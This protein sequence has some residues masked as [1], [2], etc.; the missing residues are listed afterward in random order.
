MISRV[1]PDTSD[2]HLFL[3]HHANKESPIKSL[4]IKP[5]ASLWKNNF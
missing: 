1:K 5:G 3:N 2:K 4:V